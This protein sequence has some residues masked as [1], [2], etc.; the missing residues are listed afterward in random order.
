MGQCAASES[1]RNEAWPTHCNFGVVCLVL[2]SSFLKVRMRLHNDEKV[3]LNK[4]TSELGD[5]SLEVSFVYFDTHKIVS[6]MKVGAKHSHILVLPF[7]E[8]RIQCA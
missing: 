2:G 4:L 1:G 7:L 8:D 5:D 3:H 6:A